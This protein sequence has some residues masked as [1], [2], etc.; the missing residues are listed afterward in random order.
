M[1]D[2]K[3]TPEKKK[4]ETVITEI[5]PRRY[6]AQRGRFIITFML[7]SKFNLTLFDG[8]ESDEVKRYAFYETNPVVL[9]NLAS[10]MKA[11]AGFAAGLKAK[12]TKEAPLPN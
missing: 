11:A 6:K 5:A 1:A 12:A 3:Q 4:R 8:I 10:L 2:A 9:N 7:D